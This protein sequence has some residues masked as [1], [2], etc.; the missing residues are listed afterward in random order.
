MRRVSGDMLCYYYVG[1][2]RENIK[3]ISLISGEDLSEQAIE[4]IIS[5]LKNTKSLVKIHTHNTYVPKKLA[6]QLD[7]LIMANSNIINASYQYQSTDSINA[8]NDRRK[9]A[10]SLAKQ[11]VNYY[12]TDCN[13]KVEIDALYNYCTYHNAMKSI[14]Y[15]QIQ[16]QPVLAAFLESDLLQIWKEHTYICTAF[17]WRMKQEST[18]INAILQEIMKAFDTVSESKYSAVIPY[19]REF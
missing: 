10:V 8:M 16:T 9:M 11:W 7:A 12:D 19:L 14:M 13:S 15:T 17:I 4:D 2:E 3:G 5:E 1:G 6:Q 18:I